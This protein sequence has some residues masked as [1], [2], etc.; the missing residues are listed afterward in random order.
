MTTLSFTGL[1]AFP[2]TPANA[3]DIVDTD[4]LGLLVNRLVKAGVDSIG[5]L[6]SNGIYAYLDRS[7]RSRAVAAAVEACA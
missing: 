5:L 4:K 6:G 3:E 2:P 7:E 1:S